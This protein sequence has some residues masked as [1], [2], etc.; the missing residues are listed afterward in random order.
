MA[1]PSG[2]GLDGQDDPAAWI[3]GLGIEALLLEALTSHDRECGLAGIA[4]AGPSAAREAVAALGIADL[5]AKAVDALPPAPLAET[6]SSPP[7]LFPTLSCSFS[8][9]ASEQATAGGGPFRDVT[10][11]VAARTPLTINARSAESFETELFVGRCLL[12]LRPARR[13][14]DVFY[15][16]RLFD[17]RSRG[18]EMQ[19]QGRFKRRPS[20]TVYLGGE[21]TERMQLGLVTR[22]L[23]KLILQLLVKFNPPG[24]HYSFGDRE[25]RMLPHIVLPLWRAVDRLVASPPGTA[26]PEL[27]VPL[28]E[29]EAARSA[30]KGGASLGEWDPSFTYSFSFNTGYIDL[31]HWKLHRLPMRD[32]YLSS[33]WSDSDLRLVVY[34]DAPGGGHAWRANRYALCVRITH[35]PAGGGGSRRQS[36]SRRLAAAAAA[37]ASENDVGDE[38][39]GEGGEGNSAAL[40]A[41]S[42]ALAAAGAAT[43]GVTLPHAEPASSAADSAADSPLPVTPDAVSDEDSSEEG[44]PPADPLAEDVTGEPSSEAAAAAAQGDIGAAGGVAPSA[45]LAA[46]ASAS[47]PARLVSRD[48]RGRP[49]KSYL[50][51]AAGKTHVRSSGAIKAAVRAGRRGR[52]APALG[53][54][55]DD[56]D[57]GGGAG[58]GEGSGPSARLSTAERKRR[59]AERR[60]RSTFAAPP[61]P[62]TRAG[63]ALAASAAA[64]LRRSEGDAAFLAPGRGGRKAAAAA[65]DGA[66]CISGS[67]AFGECEGCFVEMGAVLTTRALYLSEANV[68][69]GGA[70]LVLALPALLC[71]SRM[72]PSLSPFPDRPLLLVAT[73][74]RQYCLLLHSSLVADQWLAAL[75]NLRVPVD[76]GD[77]GDGATAA[78]AAGSGPA[79]G[80]APAAAAAS[81]EPSLSLQQFGFRPS[82]FTRKGGRLV[83]NGRR[84]LFQPELAA[85]S[86]LD[87][88]E[89]AAR[90]LR[91]A[92]A[93]DEA[94]P[95]S[96]PRLVAFLDAASSLKAV[97]LDGLDEEQKLAFFLNVYHTMIQHAYSLLGPPSS[98]LKAISFFNTIAYQVGGDV[99]T[100]AELEHN[101]LRAPS[102]RPKS[103]FSKWVLPKS[104]YS[105]ALTTADY[106]LNFALSCGSASG[107][108]TVPV[109]QPALLGAQLD[110][111]ASAFLARTVAVSCRSGGGGGGGDAAVALTLPKLF[112]WYARD[113]GSGKHAM[114]GAAVAMEFLRGPE[115]E[116]LRSRLAQ[117]QKPDLE[118]RYAPF[119]F[120]CSRLIELEVGRE[121]SGRRISGGGPG[122]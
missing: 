27:G 41:S 96:S 4:K 45:A 38:A 25:G 64:L 28:D 5:I 86:R 61:P 93:L 14:E 39:D 71:A 22:G 99:F 109:Y 7:P 70:S 32:V 40:A 122:G 21:V 116:L 12:L 47:I 73:V 107:L 95:L 105:F 72:D 118:I 68:G 65:A 84:L 74:A 111:V 88:C 120:A 6:V 49:K 36:S 50:V 53:R 81:D 37:R 1:Q 66:V 110:A 80:G 108:A 2:S 15:S 57:E 78:P 59:A 83:L 67:V 121:S 9:V 46:L 13:E 87:A 54:D 104:S 98:L 19:V 20:G 44:E 56:S 52:P 103:F 60:V 31:P 75:R 77:G 35:S 51:V 69:S 106:R 102:C 117:E 97:R 23:S 63:A 89:C 92:L 82:I 48:G 58:D 43:L 90:A 33:F 91:L 114:E 119:S 3:R 29:S 17:G 62:S 55:G 100:L 79:A 101:V 26:P 16:E 115:R 11:G 94:E 24:M 76:D 18:L 30:R 112:Q 10:R 85:A 42:A 113:F 34:E 8:D